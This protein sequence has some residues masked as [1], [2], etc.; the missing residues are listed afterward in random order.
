LLAPGVTELDGVTTPDG[1]NRGRA[2]SRIEQE[3]Y[4]W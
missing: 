3:T 1:T 4:S 2:P